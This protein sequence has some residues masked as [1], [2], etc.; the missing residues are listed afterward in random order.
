LAP[1]GAPRFTDSPSAPCSPLPEDRS[2]TSGMI[3]F[4]GGQLGELRH[5]ARVTLATL[6]ISFSIKGAS[7]SRSRAGWPESSDCLRIGVDHQP[8][9]G[10]EIARAS[11]TGCQAGV[12]STMASSA[13]GAVSEV[14]PAHVAPSS[15]A[16]ARSRG[17]AREHVYAGLRVDVFLPS[18]S[19][20]ARMRRSPSARDSV[21]AEGSPGEAKR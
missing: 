1:R 21:Y 14:S 15:R 4:S 9:A 5:I 19:P 11:T 3:G 18:S 17:P 16:N 20:D 10:R 6:T 2:V 12:V 13:T 7:G 8:A